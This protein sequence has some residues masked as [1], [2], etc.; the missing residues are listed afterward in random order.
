MI[1]QNF[2]VNLVTTN[3]LVSRGVPW[4]AGLY[5]LCCQVKPDITPQEFID[6]AYSTAV[7]TEIEYNS[8]S[9]PFGKVINPEGII[10]LI[11]DK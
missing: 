5:A 9:Y 3:I 8:K 6:A 10:E 11:Q 2:P 7:T 1:F 4:C